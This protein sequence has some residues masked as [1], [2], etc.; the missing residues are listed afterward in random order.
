LINRHYVLD[1]LPGRSFAEYLVREGHDVFVIDWGS[2][3]DEDRFLSFET[4]CDRYV[5]RAMRIA[6]EL[7]GSGPSGAGQVHLFGYCLGGTIAAIHAA[8]HP[9]RVATLTCIAAPIDFHDCGLLSLWTRVKSFSV[10]TL[11]EAFGNVPWP[12]M[13]ASFHLLRPTLNMM[14]GVQLIDRLADDEFLDGFFAIETWGNDNVSFPGRCY[15][16]Y[17]E[18]LYRENALIRGTLSFSGRGIALADITAPTAVVT[19]EHDNIVPPR[20]AS[21]LLEQI[22]AKE[23]EHVHLHGGHVGAMTSKKAAASLW[24]RLHRFWAA[25]DGPRPF[26][27]RRNKV[28]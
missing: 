14:K 7:A 24:P 8:C 25:H 17:I 4:V 19:F 10:R 20:S 5:G 11:V 13:Q 6:A 26:V 22:G 9:D 23:K 28:S 18:R 15:E 3:G 27:L 21:I 2:P 16:E 12:L 1:L